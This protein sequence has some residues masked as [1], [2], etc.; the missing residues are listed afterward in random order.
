MAF[1]ETGIVRKI[2]D[3]GRIAIPKDIRRVLRLRDGDPM[4]FFVE[5]QTIVL[6]RYSPIASLHPYGEAAWQAL[7]SCGV[8]PV[9][10]YDRDNALYGD[11]ARVDPRSRMTPDEFNQINTYSPEIQKVPNMDDV[12]A[13]P[14]LLEGE[15]AGF[16]AG[17]DISEA[18]IHGAEIRTVLA[19]LRNLCKE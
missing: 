3:L 11:S 10:I 4:E 18:M 6:K 12:W 14:I 2:D 9:A 16:I 8:A 13:L 17:K 19:M 7:K 5:K 15:L 1:N